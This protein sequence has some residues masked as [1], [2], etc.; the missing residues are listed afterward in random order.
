MTEQIK[1]VKN[2]S[3]VAPLGRAVLV[4]YYTPERA[5]S[6]IYIPETVRQGEVLLEQRAVVVEVGPCAWPNEP[7]R[8]KP[9]DRVMIAGFTGQAVKGPADGELYRIINDMD[10][11]AAITHEEKGHV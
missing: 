11:F 2:T 7:P 9:G 5:E 6:L 10:I 3:G 8:A 4:R 1:Q